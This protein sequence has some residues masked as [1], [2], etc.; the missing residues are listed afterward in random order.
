MTIRCALLGCQTSLT[1]D[2]SVMGK[3]LRRHRNRFHCSGGA[4]P[5][6]PS[7]ISGRNG[8]L[9]DVA[10]ALPPYETSR[11]LSLWLPFLPPEQEVLHSIHGPAIAAVNVPGQ[12]EPRP[13]DLALPPSNQTHRRLSRHRALPVRIV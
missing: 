12:E 10:N 2:G 7:V 6:R 8:R 5:P 9:R 11:I 3:S 4:L 13:S 1:A